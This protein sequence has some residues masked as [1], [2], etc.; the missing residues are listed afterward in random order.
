MSHARLDCIFAQNMKKYLVLGVLFILP[1]TVYVFFGSGVYN[2]NTL[3][4][5]TSTVSTPIHFKTAEGDSVFFKN[6]IS[7]LG[8][9]GKEVEANKAYAF[10]LAHKI[11]KK[12]HQF[13]DFQFLFLL[14][15]GAEDQAQALTTELNRIADTGNWVFAYGSIDDL[16]TLFA[17]LDTDYVLDVNGSSPYVFII[18]KEGDLRGRNDDEDVGKLYGFDARDVAEITNKMMDDVDVVLAE[19]RRALKKNDKYK[20]ERKDDFRDEYLKN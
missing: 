13:H 15:E 7:V 20:A 11:Y 2:F 19:Y 10:N 8:F 16:E 12:N 1:I 4:V 18:D 3:P 17:S 9:L 14:P 6:K 5:L